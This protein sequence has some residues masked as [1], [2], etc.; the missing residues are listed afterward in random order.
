[1]A[2]N[3][4]GQTGAKVDVGNDASLQ[5]TGAFTVM[6][7]FYLDTSPQNVEFVSKY[8][9]SPNR[10]FTLQ[11]DDDPPDDTWG[12]FWIST[13]GTQGM[14]SGWTASALPVGEWH[15]IA[16]QFI[17]STAVQIWYDGQ[18]SNENTS[19]IPFSM[20][21][22]SN[23]V[24]LGNRPDG[25]QP[26]DGSLEDIRIYNRNLSAAEMATIYAARGRDGILG[27]LVSR[28]FLNEGAPGTTPSGS[29]SVKD[30]AP[31]GNHGT[32]SGSNLYTGSQLAW[33]RR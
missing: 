29:D 14:G 32:P 6:A 18:L 3:F 25:S 1:M 7:W 28:W 4:P 16:G 13:N 26:Y 24:T 33:R 21:D 5:I 23:N 9:A 10:G 20:H 27:G 22:P 12:Y 19:G 30:H 8:A 2:I 17:P 15:H 31:N 11:T